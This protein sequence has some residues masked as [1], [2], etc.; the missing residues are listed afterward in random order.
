MDLDARCKTN[1][2]SWVRR[3]LSAP[4]GSAAELLK[5]L[6]REQ[7]ISLILGAKWDFHPNLVQKVPFYAEVL[8]TWAKFHNFPPADGEEV[9]REMI[10][11]NSRIMVGHSMLTRDQWYKWIKA[12]VL[13]VGQIS[14]PSEGRLLSQ[15][16][17]AEKLGISINFLQSLSLRSAIPFSW[18]RLLLNG[19]PG[20]PQLKYE[21][22]IQDQKFDLLNS[23]QRSWYKA[24]VSTK[25][26]EIKRKL[27]W[28]K[29][30]TQEGV[31]EVIINWEETYMLPYQITRETKLQTFFYKFAHRLCLC[32]K[33]LHTIRVKD[34][35]N[36]D[37]CHELDS[38]AHYFAE[39]L[40]VKPLKKVKPSKNITLGHQY[41]SE[42]VYGMRESTLLLL[43]YVSR[44]G[45]HY[46][47]LLQS[48]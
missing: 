18:K 12:G 37:A 8:D 23:H 34:N 16:E 35:P 2:L 31:P 46:H 43:S 32:N 48:V 45:S 38:L 36:C 33:Y 19:C 44:L 20:D 30:L 10:W 3:I 47:F 25:A 7:D 4:S 29:D 14:H 40:K 22:R 11:F 39:C 41:Q 15:E 21:V 26:Q 28:I 42:V 6:L 5:T 9:A 13:N 17:L 1:R 24:K 27:S